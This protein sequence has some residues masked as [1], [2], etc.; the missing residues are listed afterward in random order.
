MNKMTI[1][2]YVGFFVEQQCYD[3]VKKTTKKRKDVKQAH[4][5]KEAPKTK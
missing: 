5:K 2:E 4:A 1:K 3:A